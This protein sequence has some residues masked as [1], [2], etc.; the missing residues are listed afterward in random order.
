MFHRT[1][2]EI[3]ISAT[4]LQRTYKKYGV[5]YKF[6]K[7]GKKIVDYSNQHYLNLFRDM[8]ASVRAA[9]LGDKKLI[10]VDEAVFTF[11]TFSTR[12]WSSKHSRI[13]VQDSTTSI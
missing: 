5:R 9:V 4:L 1:F 2:P 8:H 10:W 12:A 13:E 3:K 7:R 6:I 11:N